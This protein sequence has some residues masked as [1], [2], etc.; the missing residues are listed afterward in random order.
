MQR[1]STGNGPWA[2]SRRK[3]RF[4]KGMPGRKENRCEG[5]RPP[6]DWRFGEIHVFPAGL[7]RN[8]Y[9]RKGCRVGR[10][11]K[12][13]GPYFDRAGKSPPEGFNTRLHPLPLAAWS[14]PACS[15]LHLRTSPWQLWGDRFKKGYVPEAKSPLVSCCRHQRLKTKKSIWRHPLWAVSGTFP[16]INS[17]THTMSICGI[18]SMCTILT[19]NRF[20]NWKLLHAQFLTSTHFKST[21]VQLIWCHP[22][23][24][25]LDTE[26]ISVSRDRRPGAG[27]FLGCWVRAVFSPCWITVLKLCWWRRD[28]W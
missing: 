14:W 24:T 9:I 2:P 25:A 8:M 12:T 19:M 15:D 7:E 10:N 23:P 1:F 6:R 5:R 28:G 22:H 18:Y 11:Q 16:Y 27:A 21:F 20:L 4:R 3:S 26:L 13:Q 17:F